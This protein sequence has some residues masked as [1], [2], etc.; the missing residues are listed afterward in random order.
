MPKK[1]YVSKSGFASC[2]SC[3]NHIRFDSTPEETVCPFCEES[4]TVSVQTSEQ[5]SRVLETL[6]KS[7]SGMVAAALAG[8]GLT[9]TVACAEPDPTDTNDNQWELGED[10]GGD[11][12]GDVEVDV[13]EE[14]NNI[15]ADYGDFPNDYDNLGEEPYNDGESDDGESDEGEDEEEDGTDD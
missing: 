2:P 8:A 6:K 4:L 5:G 10:A 14:Y 13:Y 11:A 9:L 1:I 15:Y 7:R 12:E 3:L